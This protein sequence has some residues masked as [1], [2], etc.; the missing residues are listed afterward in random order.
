MHGEWGYG[1]EE[2]WFSYRPGAG[3]WQERRID[4]TRT[5]TL[6][7]M[8]GELQPR[9]AGTVLTPGFSKVAWT[10]S[11]NSNK[12][13]NRELCRRLTATVRKMLTER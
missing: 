12:D 5:L 3:D 11:K 1:E 9:T 6:L 7:E 2:P 4:A 10:D 8:T 13:A